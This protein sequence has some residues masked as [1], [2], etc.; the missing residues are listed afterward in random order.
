VIAGKK[1][2]LIGRIQE[3]YG[4]ARE[5]AQREVD[6]FVRAMP[7]EDWPAPEEASGTASKARR[8]GQT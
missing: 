8:A 3:R 4:M 7:A 6:D 1:D 5:Q 2:Q